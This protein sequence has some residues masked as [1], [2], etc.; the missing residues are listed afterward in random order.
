VSIA[1][2]ASS[3]FIMLLEAA[4]CAVLLQLHIACAAAVRVVGL[5]SSYAAGPGI[6]KSGSYVYLLG[7]KLSANVTDLSVSGSTLL[8][9]ISSQIPKIPAN[10]DIVTITSGG[11]DL[12]FVGGLN[13][14]STGGSATTNGVTG[15]QVLQRWNTALSNIHTAAPK[16][17]IYIV[18]YL[19]ILGPDAKPGTASVPFN[20]SGL[21]YER[22]VEATLL[23]ATESAGIG[24]ESW[25]TIIPSAGRSVGNGVGSSEPWVNGNVVG[26]NGGVKWHPNILGHKNI[27]DML[28][29]K[30]S[31]TV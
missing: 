16:A 12:N 31:L 28:Y 20:A 7:S 2:V 11:N 30:I 17:K 6:P 18:E 14:F 8:T 25:V 23:N 22:G 9:M 3:I 15:A 27:A 29:S 24:K 26:S 1:P 10:S 4:L 19:T 5:G 21:T 13:A